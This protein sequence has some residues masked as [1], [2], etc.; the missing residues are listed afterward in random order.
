MKYVYFFCFLFLFSFDLCGSNKDTCIIKY[1]YC[2]I[3]TDALPQMQT[4]ADN[5]VLISFSKNKL[6]IKYYK[7]S[8]TSG[9]SV[10]EYS[11][12]SEIKENKD[13]IT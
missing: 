7:T 13:K 12:I 9:D 2:Y 3:E 1:K 6:T 4:I 10:S 8:F 11:I 5:G